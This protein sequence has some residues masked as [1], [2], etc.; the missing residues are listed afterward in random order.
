MHP[1][2]IV[3]VAGLLGSGRTELLRALFGIDRIR[4][5]EIRVN[6]APVEIDSTSAAIDRG[7]AMVPENRREQ[8]LVLDFPVSQ[9]LVLPII[10]RLKRGLVV[11]DER[12]EE[13]TA[14]YI[15]MLKVKTTG[16]DQ[17]VRFLSGGNQQK[18]VVAK[19][20]AGE[21]RILLLDDPTFG[22]DVHAK[23]EIMR[24]IDAFA[25]EGNGVLF[26]SSEFA[27]V[28]RFCHSVYIMKKGR[29]AEFLSGELTEDELLLKVQ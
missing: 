17:I 21:S 8:G 16:P 19:C 11:D 15:D 13:L 26:V 6:G 27:E 10:D 9:N 7:I 1:G 20:L 2:E 14:H 22:V 25:A 28:A 23:G 24:I 3:G 18:I 4:G 5:G 12:T 29:V